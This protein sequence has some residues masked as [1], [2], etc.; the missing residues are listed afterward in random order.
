MKFAVSVVVADDNLS[1]TIAHLS[2]LGSDI[3][4]SEIDSKTIIITD[5]TPPVKIDVVKAAPVK[6]HLKP[7]TF[8]KEHNK[9]GTMGRVGIRNVIIGAIQNGC[10]TAKQIRTFAAK[11]RYRKATTIY[12]SLSKMTHDGILSLK[13]GAYSLASGVNVEKKVV[14]VDR[15]GIGA[16]ITTFA[17]HYGP[18]TPRKEIVAAIKRAGYSE[19]SM[20]QSLAELCKSGHLGHVGR[21]EYQHPQYVNGGA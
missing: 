8:S 16:V 19:K 15:P 10:T 1:K 17:K 9:F 14:K 13:D 4:V 18:T 3:K 11:R 12:T 6:A 2:R 5:S 7:T 20:N 21:G